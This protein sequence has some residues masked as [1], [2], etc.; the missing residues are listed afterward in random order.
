MRID[1]GN[2]PSS[3][4]SDVLG[5]LIGFQIIGGKPTIFAS[6]CLCDVNL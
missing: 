4:D 5:N 3:Q 2:G 1:L 6:L